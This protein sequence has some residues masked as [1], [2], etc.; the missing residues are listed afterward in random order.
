MFQIVP[1]PSWCFSLFP[2]DVSMTGQTLLGKAWA[3]RWFPIIW[4]VGRGVMVESKMMGLPDQRD[5][6]RFTPEREPGRPKEFPCCDR[7][8]EMVTIV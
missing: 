7:T 1:R 3:E 6:C 4:K 2:L 8:Q 5:L